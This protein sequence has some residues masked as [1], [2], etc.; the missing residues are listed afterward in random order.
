MTRNKSILFYKST[1]P[2]LILIALSITI[3]LLSQALCSTKTYK[4]NAYNSKNH[5]VSQ[6]TRKRL[7]ET[8]HYELTNLYGDSDTLN[9]YFL[10]VYLGQNK[11]KSTLIVDTG[12]SIMCLTCSGTCSHCGTHENPHFQTEKSSSFKQI[13]CNDSSC[14]PFPHYKSCRENKCSFSI[15]S[16][17][18]NI[19]LLRVM[20]KAL[21]IQGL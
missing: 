13:G 16:K 9:Y 7:L 5:A 10:D 15:V 3:S 14:S 6:Y 21:N 11:E 20:E 19:S 8:G 1:I 18:L 12:S 4:L 17:F 2:L